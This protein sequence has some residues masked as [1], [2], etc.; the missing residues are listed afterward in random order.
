MAV[1]VLV[2]GTG[3]DGWC[4][5]LLVPLLRAEGHDVYTL[6]LTG[7]GAS[8]HLLHEL[9]RISLDTHKCTCMS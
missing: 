8:S 2:H 9:E 5:R 3:H 7:L 4:W 1:F 6:T